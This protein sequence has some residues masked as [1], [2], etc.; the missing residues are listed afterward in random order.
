M[1]TPETSLRKP[2][3]EKSNAFEPSAENPGHNDIAQLA[4]HLWQQRGCPAGCPEDDW[5]RA[6]QELAGRNSARRS[7][8]GSGVQ[9]GRSAVET[10]G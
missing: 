5:Y 2:E 1:T 6:E 3:E 10:E 9:D 7:S 4:Y 8:E